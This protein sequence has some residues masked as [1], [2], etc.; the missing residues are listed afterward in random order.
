[1]CSSDLG[2]RATAEYRPEKPEKSE[3]KKALEDN[4]REIGRASCRER[5]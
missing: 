2:N 5:V 1:M 4:L 3:N